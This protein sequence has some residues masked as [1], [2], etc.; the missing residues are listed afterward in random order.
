M[1][2]CTLSCE[3][4][5]TKY[6]DTVY[7]DLNPVTLNNYLSD[8]FPAYRHVPI[9]FT[10]GEPMLQYAEIY[11]FIQMYELNCYVETNGTLNSFKNQANLIDWITCSPKNGEMPK[12]SEVDELKVVW[13]SGPK[14]TKERLD[15]YELWAAEHH[16]RALYLQ[17]CFGKDNLEE[18]IQ[19]IEE[20]E[21]MWKLSVQLHKM[22]N[23]S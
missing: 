18:V 20:R 14:V 22:I 15:L 7:F 12:I 19:I 10:G 1:S 13:D 21:G 4:C 8:K 6:H 2:G 23:I 9:V 17:P 11:T 16:V 3:W 5:D